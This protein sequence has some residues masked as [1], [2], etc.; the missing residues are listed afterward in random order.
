MSLIT[1]INLNNLN[2]S[3]DNPYMKKIILLTL[4]C[5][6]L[7]AVPLT[8][9]QTTITAWTF[10]NL[11]IAQNLSPATSTGSVTATALG[12]D[13]TYG[14]PG[15][16]QNISDITVSAGSSSSILGA[17]NQAWRV[18]GG[19][20]TSTA[21]NGW[22]SSAPIGTQGAE[23]DAS[24]VGYTGLQIYFDVN[25]TKQAEANLELEYTIDGSSW[26]N[27]AITYTGTQGTIK[28]NTSSA[29]TVNGTYIQFAS[30]SWVNGITADLSG[31]SAVNN[32]PNFGIRL[33]NA[34]T[35]ADV[36]NGAG[37]AYNN[38]SGNWRYD[39]VIISGIAVPE[40]GAGSILSCGLG[41]LLHVLRRRQ[42][43][44]G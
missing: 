6:S 29:L 44:V 25:T 34:S 24:T 38:S 42:R 5:G 2:Q 3:N 36:I 33:V 9:A 15:P 39:N 8:Q 16:S 20:T 17:N 41:I 26:V 10:D 21:A 4:G 7:L 14:T 30:A 28:N 13:N 43:L 31:I 18:R 35:G 27:A 23:F 12:M 37:T 22:S 40:P 19:P 11:S 1:P 32:D